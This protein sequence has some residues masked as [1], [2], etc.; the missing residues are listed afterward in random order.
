MIKQVR[1]DYNAPAIEKGVQDFWEKDNIYGK[2]R[3]FRSEGEKFYFLDG[4]PYTT[5]S[6][7]LGTAMNKTIKDV[8]IRFWRMKGYNVRDQPGFDKIGRAHV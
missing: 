1:S 8:L 5:G 2:T 6:I 4:P 7:H 3:E